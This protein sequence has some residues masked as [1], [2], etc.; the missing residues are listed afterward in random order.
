MRRVRRPVTAAQ[1]PPGRD[2]PPR[3]PRVPPSRAERTTHNRYVRPSPRFALGSASSTETASMARNARTACNSA[4]LRCT[5]DMS[6]GNPP[7]AASWSSCS[8]APPLRFAPSVAAAGRLCRG[9]AVDPAAGDGHLCR[10]MIRRVESPGSRVV[11]IYDR[12]PWRIKLL[13]EKS[14]PA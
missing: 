11:C 4:T 1:M 7:P 2:W 5:C 6:S 12:R 3:L 13:E 9:E 14:D 10:E 8:S